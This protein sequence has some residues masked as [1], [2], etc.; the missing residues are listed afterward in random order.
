M[1]GWFTAGFN[2][3]PPNAGD[4]TL[5]SEPAAAP[6]PPPTPGPTSTT[7]SGLALGSRFVFC[8]V[9]ALV[10]LW[11]FV[12]G[13]EPAH[14]T[15]WFKKLIDITTL[16]VIV[17]GLYFAFDQA[18]KLS[19]SIESTTWNNVTA[20]QLTV[21]K[22]FIDNPGFR[23]YFYAGLPVSQGDPDYDRAA[24]IAEF[25]FDFMD[26]Y[27]SSARHLSL[28]SSNP[29]AWKNYFRSIFLKSPLACSILREELAEYSRDLASVARKP[30]R[31]SDEV[32]SP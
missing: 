28:E 8:L 3:G 5:K 23:K 29:D 4:A 19:E 6:E 17:V 2:R 21:D 24:A 16:A 1:V 30:C 20:Q 18:K 12:R 9:R 14:R 7:S 15:D 27:Y 31:W 13:P 11:T 10:H 26:G 22:L 25:L 32:V